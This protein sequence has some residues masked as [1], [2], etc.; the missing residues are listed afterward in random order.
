MNS[1]SSPPVAVASQRT[2]ALRGNFVL[3]RA[4]TLR[5]LLPQREVGAAEYIEGAPGPG[6]AGGL[7]EFGAGD[8]AL[9][10]V[11]LSGRMEPLA[12]WPQGRFVVT[13]LA[14]GDTGICFAWNETRVLIDAQL[15]LRPL[16]AAM[17]VAGS[18]IE[19]YVEHEG[20]LLFCTTARHV[21]EAAGAAAG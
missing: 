16:P 18:P 19:G 3:L 7:F 9:A 4:D 15:E 2:T 14:A 17:R 6:S 5:L 13:R 21:I 1:T 12:Q 11:A 10:V 20:E 8:E